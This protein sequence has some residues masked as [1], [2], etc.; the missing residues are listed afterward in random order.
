MDGLI[1]T[2]LKRIAHPKGDILHAI[3][4]TDPGFAGFGELYFTIIKYGEIKG[5]KKH[6]VMTM[7][8]IVPEGTVRFYLRKELDTCHEIVIG[9]H[10]YVRLTISP[11][12][13]VAFEGCGNGLNLV[14]NLSNIPHD[15]NEAE[16][17]QWGLL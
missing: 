4:E 6:N 17:V 5:W 7:N 16:N 14:A 15:P 12:V 3:K 13:W 8:L 1:I 10:N 11:K 2:P 9:R